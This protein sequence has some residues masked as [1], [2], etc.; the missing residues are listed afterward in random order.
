MTAS[1]IGVHPG[2]AYPA[3]RRKM[4]CAVA[5][6]FLALVAAPSHADVAELSGRVTWGQRAVCDRPQGR[7]LVF[8]GDAGK[9][10]TAV[11]Q[12][13][14]YSVR[15]EPGRYRVTLRCGG[16]DVESLDLIGYPTP[17]RQDLAF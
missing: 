15:L 9:A 13:G 10:E 17:T 16:T 2:M 8:S 3:P 12:D 4:A 6:A 7:K 1:R 14:Y 11:A 5:S